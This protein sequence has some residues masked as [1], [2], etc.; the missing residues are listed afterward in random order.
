MLQKPPCDSSDVFSAEPV[1]F[2]SYHK[3]ILIGGQEEGQK[4]RALS[5]LS[6]CLRTIN[7]IIIVLTE[8]IA[9]GLQILHRQVPAA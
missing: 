3:G 6:H 2:D 4:L 9:S 8:R 5:T 1:A 7:S